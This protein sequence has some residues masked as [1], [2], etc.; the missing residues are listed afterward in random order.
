VVWLRVVLVKGSSM[1]TFYEIA[2]AMLM[3]YFSI[4]EQ[5]GK[6]EEEKAAFFQA[7]YKEFKS[8]DPSCLPNV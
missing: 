8:K 5:L 7:S 3:I 1:L 4:M 2:K 6:T